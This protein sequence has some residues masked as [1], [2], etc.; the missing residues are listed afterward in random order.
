MVKAET[1]VKLTLPIEHGS[2]MIREL[3]MRRPKAKDLR[4]LPMEPS[5]GDMLDL[6][7]DLTGHPPSVIDELDI[8]DVMAIT[9][10]LENFMPS[11]QGTGDKGSG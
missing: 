6:A 9:K 1:V 11:G 4:S 3:V 10:V 2:E 7:G 5:M 8:D